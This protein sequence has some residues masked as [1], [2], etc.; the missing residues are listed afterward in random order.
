V[1]MTRPGRRVPRSKAV[2]QGSIAYLG[3]YSVSETLELIPLVWKSH[4]GNKAIAL[5][6][7]DM[8]AIWV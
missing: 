6:L 8:V 7:A 3:T 5:A 1:I 2:V 4:P